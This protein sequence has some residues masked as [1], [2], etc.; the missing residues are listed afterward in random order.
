MKRIR[1][2]VTSLR[3]TIACGVISS[4]AFSTASAGESIRVLDVERV[5]ASQPASEA[6]LRLTVP[7]RADQISCDVLI[8]GASTGG[9]A[10]ALAVARSGKSVCMTEETNWIGGQMTAQGVSALDENRYIEKG[11]G[12]ASYL[13]VRQQIRAFYKTH[14]ALSRLGASETAF[15]PGNCWVSALCFS[16]PG[17][18]AVLRGRLQP[19]R[20]S[21]VLR[22]FLRTKAVSVEREGDRI[23]SVVTY[24]FESHR[25]I[26]FTARCFIDA[27]DLGELLPLAGAAYVTGAEP[28]SLTG[29]P[30]ALPG[31]GDPRDTQSFTYTFV[32]GLDPGHRHVIPEPSGYEKNRTEQPYTLTVSYGKGKRLTY[33]MFSRAPDTPGSFWTYRRLV[34]AENFVPPRAPREMSLIN[35]PGNDYC[36]LGLLSNDPAKVAEALKQAKLTSLGL[37]YW[38]QRDVPR[39]GGGKGYPELE[40]LTSELGSRDGLSQFPYIRESRR[41]LALT[42]VKEQ[43]ISALYQRGP[44]AKQFDDST[45]IGFYPID[46]HSCSKNDISSRTKPFQIPLGALI[47]RDVSNL[48]AGSK[49]IGVTHIASGAYR[50]HPIE[51]AIGEAAGTAAAFALSHKVR[52]AQVDHDPALLRGL[53]LELLRNGVPIYWLDDLG[54]ADPSFVAA[55]ILAMR[56]IFGPH[57][58]NLHFEPRLPVKRFEAVMALA[59]LVNA[60]MR[61][62]G[63][64]PS[65]AISKIDVTG[66]A[67]QLVRRDYL[68]GYFSNPVEMNQNLRWPDLSMASRKFGLTGESLAARRQLLTR[69][70]FALWLESVNLP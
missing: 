16:V 35:W 69:A 52:P 39:R 14:Y 50:L 11:G 31:A 67:L 5:R 47:S 58:R 56:G 62:G 48:L 65:A 6:V 60:G 18:L 57:N 36:G 17:A 66:L 8:V 64:C 23:R 49:D 59:R 43:D 24:G 55:Q 25:W 28:R 30:H 70:D 26:T 22:I 7:H 45:D 9:V 34:A 2:I 20:N 1:W 27:T 15:N 21:G 12:T 40:Q 68:P 61:A 19:L 38:L 33:R 37:A 3:L 42:T 44:R 41:I 13:L 46:I 63:R 29:E 54:P 51:W 32:M 4:V 10:A 53:Q